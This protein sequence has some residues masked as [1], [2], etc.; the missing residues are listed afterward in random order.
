MLPPMLLP[1]LLPLLQRYDEG[2]IA[3]ME[4]VFANSGLSPTETHLP[5]T[6]NPRF[7]G[8]RARTDLE[9]ARE[10]CSMAVCGAVEGLLNKVGVCV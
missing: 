4:R 8:S 6:L 3:F 1:L 9:A 2:D 10:E 5:P 7:V